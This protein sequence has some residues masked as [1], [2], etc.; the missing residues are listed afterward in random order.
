MN[1]NSCSKGNSCHFAHGNTELRRRNEELP[2]EVKFKMM[3]VPYN[4]Y[5]TQVC[6][7]YAQS[8]NCH[9]G[10]NCTYAHGDEETRAP[11]QEIP[12]GLP[13]LEG[14]NPRAL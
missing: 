1:E 3:N 12:G 4:N 5:K 14:T 9:Y 8:K 13:S 10:K 6:K 7:Y 2:V 11:Y